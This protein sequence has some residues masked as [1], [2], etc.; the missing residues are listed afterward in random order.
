MDFKKLSIFFNSPK[1]NEKLEEAQAELNAKL[2]EQRDL[3]NQLP[4]E[5]Q[6][7]QNELPKEHQPHI[8]RTITEVP[9][10]WESALA[11]WR[12]LRELKPAIRSVLVNL[13]IKSDYQSKKDYRQLQELMLNTYYEWNLLDKLISCSNQLKMQRNFWVVRTI[14]NTIKEEIYNVLYD[15]FDN[16]P[17]ATI[18]ASVFDPRSKQMHGWPEELKEKTSPLLKSKYENKNKRSLKETNTKYSL[19]S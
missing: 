17:N 16:P 14:I 2:G 9:A 11:S 8:L 18:L 19:S 13:S 3:Q 1:Q 10:R 7:N 4:N 5:N 15:Y 6:D 12:R